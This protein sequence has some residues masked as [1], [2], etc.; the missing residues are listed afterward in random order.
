MTFS[1]LRLGFFLN[2]KWPCPQ[3]LF[4]PKVMVS[5]SLLVRFRSS[6]CVGLDEARVTRALLCM[7]PHLLKAGQ[8]NQQELS[9][10]SLPPAPR[11]RDQPC[12]CLLHIVWSSLLESRWISLGYSRPCPHIVWRP[13]MPCASLLKPWFQLSSSALQTAA[14]LV[15]G[16]QR[17]SSTGA[18]H[19]QRWI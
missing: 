9:R 3:P 7:C 12:R 18:L 16:L 19:R 10:L 4:Y 14:Q 8:N 2:R 5:L 17:I 11:V 1:M 13:F 15:L 6:R